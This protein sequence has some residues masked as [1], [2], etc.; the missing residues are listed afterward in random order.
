MEGGSWSFELIFDTFEK[1]VDNRVKD[2]EVDD[3][4]STA[5]RR[6]ELLIGN[7]AC[8]SH[9]YS[10]LIDIHQVVLATVAD[11]EHENELGPLDRSPL[12]LHE[13]VEHGAQQL[14]GSFIVLLLVEVERHSG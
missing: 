8:K 12:L 13:V 1:H 7:Q 14:H 5:L 4:L 10:L 2:S 6:Q 9:L 3:T 11:D